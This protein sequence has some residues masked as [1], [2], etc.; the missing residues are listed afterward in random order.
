MFF[1][2]F[3]RGTVFGMTPDG[4]VLAGGDSI[5]RQIAFASTNTDGAVEVGGDSV[6]FSRTKAHSADGAAE[7]GGDGSRITAI[8][9]AADGAVMAGGD[10]WPRKVT[11]VLDGAAIAGGDGFARAV[12]LAA[13]TVDGAIVAGGD[14]VVVYRTFTPAIDGAAVIGGD[15][16]ALLRK[17]S[18][19]I[20]GAA[21]AGGDGLIPTYRYGL[22]GA[23][24][25]GGDAVDVT[26]VD[27]PEGS[28][29]GPGVDGAAMVGG[30]GIGETTFILSGQSFTLGTDR[31]R[32]QT[33]QA[34]VLRAIK[35]RLIDTTVFQSHEIYLAV[36]PLQ[37]AEK[38]P[39]NDKMCAVLLPRKDVD[40]GQLAG[41][42]EEADFRREVLELRVYTRL[43]TDRFG[44]KDNWS[45]QYTKGSYPIARRVASKFQI[46][47]LANGAGTVIVGEPTRIIS[48]GQPVEIANGFGATSVFVEVAFTEREPE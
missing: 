48:I 9:R 13:A 1:F 25:V 39:S 35:Q 27:G 17:V 26:F 6:L 2:F 18:P 4:A 10:P 8:A 12:L 43:F 29:Y 37:N 28:T 24:C 33:T 36:D 14:S 42:G 38:T 19:S 45:T 5:A 20:D 21:I 7:A 44:H 3:R 16:A 32:G 22:D 11:Y 47:D 15:G 34:E 46:H 23:V 31:H 40:Q 41:G 30:D